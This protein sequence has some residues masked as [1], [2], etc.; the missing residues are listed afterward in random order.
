MERDAFLEG[1]RAPDEQERGQRMSEAVKNFRVTWDDEAKVMRVEW[2]PRAVCRLEEAKA[3]TEAIRA[4]GHDSVPLYVDMR[5]M[6]KFERSAR[7]HFVSD[8]GGVKVVALVA[9]S[10]VTKM[11]ANFFIGMRRLP[12]PIQMFTDE[13]A[14]VT[15]LQGHR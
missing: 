12:V 7:E 3:V 14:A 1:A 10:P 15:W 11:M 2:L 6:A 13:V 4:T 9:G 8:P 5:G